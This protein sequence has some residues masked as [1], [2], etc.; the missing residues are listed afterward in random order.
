MNRY[1]AFEA[2]STAPSSELITYHVLY[3]I[4]VGVRSHLGRRRISILQYPRNL[5]QRKLDRS[6][7]YSAHRGRTHREM[8]IVIWCP[9]FILFATLGSKLQHAADDRTQSN[10][11]AGS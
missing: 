1:L 8:I 7:G 5:I 3:P 9:W 6:L 10:S 11:K 4:T 2:K